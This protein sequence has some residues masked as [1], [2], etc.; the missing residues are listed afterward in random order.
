MEL[1]AEDEALQLGL[2]RNKAVVGEPSRRLRLLLI[3][4]FLFGGP[5]KAAYEKKNNSRQGNRIILLHPK[6]FGV[7][8]ILV[9]VIL[10]MS[11]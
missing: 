10:P 7:A 8:R 4:V 6:S 5:K 1:S 9:L 2:S 11:I 3:G